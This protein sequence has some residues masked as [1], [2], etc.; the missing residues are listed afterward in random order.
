M[1]T[2]HPS[3][4]ALVQQGS[5]SSNTGAR[6]GRSPSPQRSTHAVSLR[7]RSLEDRTRANVDAEPERSRRGRARADDYFDGEGKEVGRTERSRSRD[8]QR[9]HEREER[10][11]RS[12]DRPRRPSPEYAEY[13]RPASPHSAGDTSSAPWR[14]QESMYPNR[15]DKAPYMSSAGGGSDFLERYDHD[16][17]STYIVNLF[18]VGGSSARRARSAYGHL[19]PKRLPDRSS[20]FT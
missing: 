8:K 1:A 2:I 9:D 16:R 13:K 3:R 14:Q 12:R 20:T 10:R 17:H 6:R 5:R 19:L 7:K 4:L 15:R 11:E 18:A